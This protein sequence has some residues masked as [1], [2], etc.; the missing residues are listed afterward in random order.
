MPTQIIFGPGELKKLA[1]IRLPGKKALIVISSGH[2]MKKYGYLDNVITYLKENNVES[3]VYDKILPNPTSDHVEE[4][5]QLA[6]EHCCDFVIGLGGGSS[7]DSAKG[8]AV[9][10]KNPGKYWDYVRGGSGKGNKIENGVLPIIAIPTTAGTGTETD[11]W[12]VITKT[13]TNEKIGFGWKNH[14]FPTLSIVDPE[15]MLSVSPKLTAY[16]G[17]D[18]FFHSVEGY[19]ASISQPASDLYALESIQLITKYLPLAVADG[20][21]LE[22]RT[23]VAWASTA[24]GIVEAL[25]SCLSHHSMGHALGAFYPELPHGAGLAALSIPYFSYIVKKEP[26]NKYT[27]L[28]EI[29]GEDVNTLPEEK[30]AYSFIT[31]LKKLIKNIGLEDLKLK[32]FG[33]KKDAA[34]KLAKNSK[35][36]MG[37]LY[38]V[39]PCKL[40]MEEVISIFETCF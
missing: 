3:I 15:L 36:T 19:L 16:Q 39:D 33:V 32:D 11:P 14:T 22:A 30:K 9:M 6:K 12:A 17:I 25:S 8:I 20:Q 7:I 26:N 40:S 31:A 28:A 23:A 37:H 24:A 1:K 4:G 13:D 34:E 29:M 21:N 35:D 2:S 10:A 38:K 5:G 18:A 27:K